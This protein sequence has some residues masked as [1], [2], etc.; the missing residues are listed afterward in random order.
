MIVEPVIV[1]VIDEARIESYLFWGS[2]VVE[3]RR[4]LKN[5]QI[6]VVLEPRHTRGGRAED[7]PTYLGEKSVAVGD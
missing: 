6:V 1:G 4:V 5:P 2:Y 3:I 7:G